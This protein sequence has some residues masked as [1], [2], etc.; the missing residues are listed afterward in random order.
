MPRKLLLSVVV[1][2]ALACVAWFWWQNHLPGMPQSAAMPQASIADTLPGSMVSIGPAPGVYSVT[3]LTDGGVLMVGEGVPGK[4][5]IKLFNP[6][7]DKVELP[8]QASLGDGASY[9]LLPDGR[10]LVAGGYIGEAGAE[11][12]LYDPKDGNVASVGMLTGNRV[13]HTATLLRDGRVLIVGGNKMGKSRNVSDSGEGVAGH[14]FDLPPV[15]QSGAELYDPVSARFSA[16]GTLNVGRSGHSATLLPDGRVL[17]AGGTDASGRS[18]SSAELWDPAKG[19]FTLTTPLMVG[20]VRHTATL[21][22]SG[23][24]LFVGGHAVQDADAPPF[25]NAEMYDPNAENSVEASGSRFDSTNHSATLLADGRV[26]L[27]GD[28]AEGLGAVEVYDPTKNRFTTMPA[29]PTSRTEHAATLLADG[30]VLISGGMRQEVDWEGAA[31]QADCWIWHPEDGKFTKAPPLKEARVRHTALRLPSGQV[32]MANNSGEGGI[33]FWDGTGKGRLDVATA[34]SLLYGQS[35]TLLKDGRVLI[36]GGGEREGGVHDEAMLFDPT[37]RMLHVTGGMSAR[38]KEASATLL[39]DGRVLV[40]GGISASE[41]GNNFVL[42]S[43]EIYDP[44]TGS[45]SPTGRLNHAREGHQSFLLTDGKVLIVGGSATS[46]GHEGKVVAP[47]TDC[48]GAELWNPVTGTFADTGSP[49]NADCTST[50]ARL[51]DGRVLAAGGNKAPTGAE[52]Y[53]PKSGRFATTGNMLIPRYLSHALILHDGRVLMAGTA[54]PLVVDK[55]ESDAPSQAP[56]RAELYEPDKGGFVGGFGFAGVG[57]IRHVTE[58]PG[59]KL[60]V[61]GDEG[62]AVFD[63]ARLP[64]MTNSRREP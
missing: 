16:A 59:G 30:S 43:A 48:P 3:S 23:K 20:R 15:M 49:I 41:N 9:T 39:V 44:K 14:A 6:V 11:S 19:K 57:P 33:E 46:D 40:T 32:L 28:T 36:A 17:V 25:V 61:I 29:M 4:S 34:V 50:A 8:P 12:W 38:R 31:V 2:A 53:D 5:G 52:I 45:F 24:V 54:S 27:L 26:L 18:L 42:A 13:G 10:V 1:F 62:S 51:K 56:A 22:S 60:L 63:E 37:T 35:A 58:L 47:L 64:H 7:R 21:L 55:P